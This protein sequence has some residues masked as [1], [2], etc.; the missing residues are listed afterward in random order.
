MAKLGINRFW[1]KY[2]GFF[3]VLFLLLAIP[4]TSSAAENKTGYKSVYILVVDKLSIHDISASSTPAINLLVQEKGSVGLVSNRTLRGNNVLDNSLTIGAGNLARAYKYGLK[5]FNRE[6]T[7]PDREQTAGHLYQNLTGFNAEEAS[8]VLVN[9]PE[10][11]LGIEKEKV[12]TVPGAMGEVLRQNNL[13]VCLLGNADIGKTKNR[14]SVAIAM[15]AR[16]QIPL[17]NIGP[18]NYTTSPDSFLTCTTNYKF[19]QKQFL[20]YKK[21]ADVM[22]I[23]LPDLA[24]LEAEYTAFPDVAETEKQ[25]ILNRIDR[26][27]NWVSGQIDPEH[28]L[29]L[30]I[31][32]SPSKKQI[33]DKNTFTPLIAY[34]NGFEKGFLTSATTRRDY[35]IANTDIAPT[36]LSFFGLEDKTKTMIGQPIEVI[37]TTNED[38]LQE[39]QKLSA[40]TSTT[41]RLRSPLIK[42]YVVFQIIVILLALVAIFWVN[43]LARIL[44]PFI[45]ALVA[46]PLVLLPLGKTSFSSD[47]LYIVAAV[48]ATALLTAVFLKFSGGNDSRAFVALGIITI[49][50]LNADILTGAAMI[51]SSVLGYDPMVGARFYG[52]GNE[53]MGILLGSSIA[54]VSF[55]FEKFRNRIT[56]LIISLFFFFECW[57]IAAP[58]LGANSDGML[59]APAAFLVT[60]LL[61]GEVKFQPSLFFSA[62]AVV[63]LLA[64]SL[65]WYDMNR[66]PELQSHIGRAAEQI[67]TGGWKELYTIAS[68]K[69]AMNIKLI[70]YT[71]WS[72]VFLVIL[73]VLSLLVYRPVGA[74]KKLM[75]EY[76]CIVKGFAGIIAGALVGLVVNDSG[77]VA[78]STTSIYLIVPLLLFMLNFSEKKKFRS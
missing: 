40:N 75:L 42:G 31:T 63:I 46:V 66:P 34:G 45:V 58:S 29:L 52:I 7:V 68:R 43:E 73:L 32:P 65:T 24:R 26:F 38:T 15:D 48:T 13:K 33:E 20:N 71:I 25:R 27:V 78:A 77:I 57:I 10:I 5:G 51:Q 44:K 35:I 76:P 47:W 54:V 62:A 3:L 4:A 67:A 41:S 50:T 19:I 28:D 17:G 49:L 36:V 72:R 23:E 39:A 30:I 18:Q 74:V 53:Y 59:T 16:G 22:V 8:C 61:L 56:L 64:L 37:S 11:I 6:E 70:K 60:M 12:N 21:Q 69:A 1:R 9:L 55:I 2:L 14:P